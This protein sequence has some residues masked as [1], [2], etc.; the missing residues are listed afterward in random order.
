MKVELSPESHEREL[1][2]GLSTEELRKLLEGEKIKSERVEIKM[3]DLTDLIKCDFSGEYP[4]M[5]FS[6]RMGEKIIQKML[7]FPSAEELCLSKY[8]SE[9][10]GPYRSFFYHLAGA[11]RN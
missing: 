3:N 2:V 1:Y 7:T 5:H 9:R 4:D 6:I 11:R 8:V 10:L